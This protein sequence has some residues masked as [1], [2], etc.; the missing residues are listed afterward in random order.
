[1]QRTI[2]P[3]RVI[4]VLLLP[5]FAW[6]YQWYVSTIYIVYQLQICPVVHN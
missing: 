2:V 6:K 5:G 1:M 3:V 4:V